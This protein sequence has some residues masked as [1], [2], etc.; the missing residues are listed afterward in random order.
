MTAKTRNQPQVP[1][2]F[3]SHRAGTELA[4]SGVHTEFPRP[5]NQPTLDIART[6]QLAADR[7]NRDL[8]EAKLPE[9][10]VCL[11]RRAGSRGYFRADALQCDDGRVVD[12]IGL[13]PTHI[14]VA[15]P[16]EALRCLTRLRAHQWRQK[17]CAQA[18]A[19]RAGTPGYCDKPL[20]KVLE[21]IGLNP[22]SSGQP[23]G[24]RT[25]YGIS[26]YVVEGGPFDLLA[27]EMLIAGE[28]LTWRDS[29]VSVAEEFGFGSSCRTIKQ[30]K[31]RQTRSKFTCPNIECGQNA[32]AAHRAQLRCG[33]CDLP[34]QPVSS[35]TR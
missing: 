28:L 11:D 10:A 32:W 19:G 16:Y 13:N 20:A 29:A 6:L 31:P 24:R 14:A 21:L 23:G 17:I 22:S 33:F 7:I 25:G 2:S 15:G 1:D 35:G 34:M 12:Q 26:D 5:A 18:S 27:R 3:T 30:P 8:F 9:V 4:L